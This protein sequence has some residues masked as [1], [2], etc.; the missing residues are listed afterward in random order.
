[1]NFLEILIIGAISIVF[2]G[3][4][5]Q[6]EKDIEPDEATY[7]QKRRDISS[8]GG[9]DP[10]TINVKEMELLRRGVKIPN[11][12]EY[13]DD[14]GG[15]VAELETLLQKYANAA[16]AYKPSGPQK[17]EFSVPGDAR[18]VGQQLLD[19]MA[20]QFPKEMPLPPPPVEYCDL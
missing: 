17:Y 5:K 2:W 9:P 13:G 18:N 12:W 16:P 10:L 3:N 15:Y 4:G 14:L 7:T 6:V 11:R 20:Y 19:M 8:G 1:M